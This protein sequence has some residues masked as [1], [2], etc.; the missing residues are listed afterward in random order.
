MGT[1]YYLLK[2]DR[3]EIYNLGKGTGDWAAL[4][5]AP[6]YSGAAEQGT[7]FR[8]CQDVEY[9]AG[10]LEADWAESSCQISSDL[11]DYFR[12]VA[13]DV[14]RWAGEDLVRSSSD[15]GHDGWRDPDGS[16]DDGH[17][18]G[19]RY[20]NDHPEWRRATAADE[21]SNGIPGS[22]TPLPEA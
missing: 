2:D 10:L 8:V 16:W 14:I 1:E 21:I 12:L 4:L 5:A 20:S 6:E 3:R 19:S 18:T 7:P 17:V 13:A 15:S 9:V 11:P 22:T